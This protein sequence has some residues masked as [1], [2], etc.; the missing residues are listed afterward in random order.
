MNNT[1]FTSSLDLTVLKNRSTS[2]RICS[3]ANL[4]ASKN[5]LSSSFS[6][7]KKRETSRKNNSTDGSSAIIFKDLNYYRF[8]SVITK[9]KYLIIEKIHYSIRE[10]IVF[11][12]GIQHQTTCNHHPTPIDL[13]SVKSHPTRCK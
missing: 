3:S 9:F 13:P 6:S 4:C 1:H 7:L 12:S 8:F 2:L 5:R 10:N 11:N